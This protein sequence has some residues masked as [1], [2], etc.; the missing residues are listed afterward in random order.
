MMK[1]TTFLRLDGYG[2]VLLASV[3]WGTIGVA[4]Q[5]IYSNE[6]ASPLFINLMRTIIATPIL[7]L[8][9][10]RSIR[11]QLFHVGLRDFGV[12]CLMGTCLVLSQVM[13]FSGI[14]YAGV[15]ISTLLTLCVPAILVACLSML[16]KLET[17]Q[18]KIII[19]LVC[20]LIGCGL[21]ISITSS[22]T[23]YPQLGLGIGYS[24][25]S[26]ML[27][28]GMLLCGR[29]VATQYHPLQVNAI[30]FSAGTL[31]LLMIT[32][33]SDVVVIQTPQAWSLVFYLGLIPTAFAYLIFQMGLK[34]V[35]ATTA[36]IVIM[37]DPLVAA[38]LAWL[39][40]GE[41]LPFIGLV[42]AG[43]LLLSLLILAQKE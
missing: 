22:D 23:T 20:A 40:F 34:T 3:L 15:T 11:H 26:A 8:M 41:T 33:M 17:V 18:R 42:G 37:I 6:D 16:F 4:T 32:L 14:R 27:Y 29:F 39:M 10:W 13:Y 19:A 1:Q 5:M 36:S 24:L 9:A 7:L 2:W 25:V 28:A 21:L 35:S 30:G 38:G 31:V 43:L 12:M